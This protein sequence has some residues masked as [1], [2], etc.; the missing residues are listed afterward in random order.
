MPRKVIHGATEGARIFWW[1]LYYGVRYVLAGRHGEDSDVR[2]SVVVREYLIRMGPLYMKAGQVLAT[3]SGLLSKRATDEFRSFFSDL[4]PMS[5]QALRRTLA[6]NLPAPVEEVF[7]HFD[8]EPTAVGSV[9]QVHRATLRD[10][11]LVAVKVVKQGVRERLDASAW[12]VATLLAAAHAVAPPLRKYDLPAHFAE[13]RP[14]VTGQCDMLREA[15]VQTEVGLNFSGH[16]FVRVP[17]PHG[18]LCSQDVLVMDFM[19]GTPGQ[20]PERAGSSPTVLARRLQDSFYS[21]VF[22]HGLFHVDPHPGNVLFGAQG[23]LLLL[24]FGL[25]GRLSEDEKWDLASFYYACIRKEWEL[26]AERF[27]R[28]FVVH[29]GQLEEN[30]LEYTG[31]LTEILREH[32]ENETSKWSTMAFFDDGTRLLRR[33][34][35][36]VTTGFSLLALGLL[37]G[38]GFISQTD[39]EIDIWEN[40]RRF[41]DRFSPYMNEGVRE[42]FDRTIGPRIPRSLA[43]RSAAARYLVAPTHLDRFAL[44]SAFP[45]IIESASGSRINDIDGNE[46]IDL[47]C[48]YGPH[49][50][51]YA[52]PAVVDAIGAAAARGAV[53]AVGNPDE[54]RHAERIAGAFAPGTKVILS[55]SGTEAVVMAFRLA[56]AYTRKD[57]VAKFEGHYH[58]FSDQAMVSSWFRH[59]G[60]A[61]RPDP[62]EGSAGAHRAAV[63]ETLVLQYGDPSSLDRIASHAHQL[64]CVILEPMPAAMADFDGAFLQE[65]RDVCTRHGVVLIFDE[66]VTGFRVGYGGVQHLANVFPDLTCL[67]KIIGGGLPCGAVA[68]RPE[69]VEMA[70]T[71][72]DPFLDVERRAFV[73]GTLSGNSVTSAAGL[74]V[75]DQLQAQPQIYERLRKKSVALSEAMERHALER[76]IPC[77]IKGQYSIFSITFDYAAPKLV[78]DRLAGSNMKANLAL[79]YH[80]RA[81]GVYVPELHTLM[82]GDAHSDAD[83]EKVEQAFADSLDDMLRDG[84]FA[85]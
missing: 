85:L 43:A 61:R 42:R 56:R 71:T 11:G 72:A 48:G 73:G 50:L 74:A 35:A 51:G 57:R 66:I 80:M 19:D 6:R 58:G 81:R 45:L 83:L 68:G 64:A 49:I 7:E 18:A 76:G 30:Q 36:R 44:P 5:G 75:L 31:K 13:I 60:D 26:A 25:F 62:V 67:G 65:L 29:S 84:F 20:E 34:G 10:G 55:N 15:R 32:F 24:D 22:F 27:T 33:Y 79:A 4:P 16:S 3:Q 46:Y 53:N 52:H 28:A 63:A 2:R 9:A 14:L 70:R 37:T 69:I 38:E 78:R 54:L 8:W 59:R 17:R 39:P 23:T 41:T 1:S 77:D 40:A 21:M 47:S 82:L 12:L